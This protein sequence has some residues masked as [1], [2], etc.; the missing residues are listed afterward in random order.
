[1]NPTERLLI[2]LLDAALSEK[3]PDPALAE[4]VDFAVLF[5]LAQEHKIDA[6]LLNALLQLPQDKLPPMPI[7]AAWQENAMVTMMAQVMLV[8]SLHQLTAALEEAGVKAVMLKGAAIKPLYPEPDLRTMSDADLLIAPQQQDAAAKVFE[9]LGFTLV[10][11]EPG[12]FVYAGGDGLRVELHIRLFDEASYGFLSRLDEAK[13][14]PVTLARREAVH[15]GEA[16]VFPPMEHLLFMLCHMAK[17][18]IT[19]GFGMR[20]VADF[21]LFARAND[22]RIDWTAFWLVSDQL[23]VKAFASALLVIGVRYLS[24]PTGKWA[25]GAKIDERAADALLS[26]LIDAGVFGNRTE[27][28]KRSAAVVYRAAAAKDGDRGRIRRALFPAASTLKAPFLYARRHKWLLPIAWVHRLGR[29]AFLMLTGKANRGELSAS[30][31]IA[32][33]RLDL[34]SRLGLRDGADQLIQANQPLYIE[35][36]GDH[37]NER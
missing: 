14:F 7:L 2:A 22:D 31:Q 5:R 9:S 27:E 10:E 28:R 12:V 8:E 13:M 3:A 1:M 26:D 33:E 19:T 20:Q 4:G 15:G 21:C 25:A 34:L 16:W 35:E 36:K 29:Y 17:H 11:T 6:M 23:G 32:D 30:V 37:A 24:M 18:M